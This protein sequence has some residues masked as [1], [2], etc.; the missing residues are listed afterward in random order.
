MRTIPLHL[1][2]LTHMDKETWQQQQA[3]H[4]TCTN[5]RTGNKQHKR[6]SRRSFVKK[7]HKWDLCFCR[8]KVEVCLWFHHTNSVSWFSATCNN[9]MSLSYLRPQS[10]RLQQ[11]QSD[12]ASL[13][14]LETLTLLWY[15]HS[16]CVR[17]K[18]TRCENQGC[19]FIFIITCM[20]C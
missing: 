7:N 5:T 1:W 2:S 16:V 6:L 4:H 20:V 13:I 12:R 14:E 15:K 17:I 10:S 11:P 8:S 18:Q 9:K 19:S 3:G